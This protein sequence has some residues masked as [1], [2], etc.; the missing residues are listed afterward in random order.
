MKDEVDSL[1]GYAK[2]SGDLSP[3]QPLLAQDEGPL[4]SL[5]GLTSAAG[6]RH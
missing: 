5:F 3:S 6:R 1:S 4:T 2:L